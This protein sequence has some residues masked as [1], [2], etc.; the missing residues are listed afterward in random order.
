MELEELRAKL[1]QVQKEEVVNR[2]NERNVIDIISALVALKELEVIFTEDGRE[3]VTKKELRR[4]IL[5]EV[6]LRG[7]RMNITELPACL[8]VAMRW[9]EA[10]IPYILRENNTISLVNGELVTQEYEENVAEEIQQLLQHTG[11]CT[12]EELSQRFNLSTQRTTEILVKYIG[13]MIG[14]TLEEGLVY[15]E[16]T[17]RRMKAILR[18]VCVGAARPTAI[19]EIITQHKLHYSLAIATLDEMIQGKQLDGQLQRSGNK[20][21]FVP[22]LFEKRREEAV[23]SFYRENGFLVYKFVQQQFDIPNPQQFLVQKYRVKD[24]D[25]SGLALHTCFVSTQRIAASLCPHLDVLASAQSDT[26][27][28]TLCL[29]VRAVLPMPLTDADLDLLFETSPLL[30]PYMDVCKVFN[31]SVLVNVKIAIPRI[32]NKVEE[33]ALADLRGHVLKNRGKPPQYVEASESEEEVVSKRKGKVKAPKKHKGRTGPSLGPVAAKMLRLVQTE[34]PEATAAVCESILEQQ[35]HIIA[36]IYTKTQTVL[37]STDPQGTQQKREHYETQI[38]ELWHEIQLYIK[39]VTAFSTFK[40][41]VADE[42][43]TRHLLS[44]VCTELVRFIVLDN[45]LDVDCDL[46]LS[47]PTKEIIAALPKDLR[48][49]L[50]A[51]QDTLVARSVQPFLE[52]M[53]R[54]TSGVRLFLKPQDKKRERLYFQQRREEL[55]RRACMHDTSVDPGNMLLW[56][57]ILI[58]AKRCNVLLHAPFAFLPYLVDHLSPMAQ[59]KPANQEIYRFLQRV[60]PMVSKQPGPDVL[61]ERTEVLAVISDLQ[62]IVAVTDT[63]PLVS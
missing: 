41:E 55:S 33:F 40:D 35:E 32:L 59:E 17:K 11:Q 20:L 19:S 13:S 49:P 61:V 21:S 5:E 51:L 44:T 52:E 45:S 54:V 9:I 24:K 60:L 23:H 63:N 31:S 8:N 1:Q 39:A 58:Y 26:A 36:A 14:G 53:E 28:S 10:E 6:N 37:Y 25:A 38:N 57:C 3:Y 22:G 7:G 2:L 4:E 34:L 15:T 18:G 47:A 62:K 27:P 42:I 30:A 46:D 48:N 29:D 43:L 56:L 12:T 16:S 50:M